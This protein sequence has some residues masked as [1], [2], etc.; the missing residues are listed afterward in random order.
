MFEHFFFLLRNKTFVVFIFF[1]S[2]I[3]SDTLDRN[4]FNIMLCHVIRHEDPV[5]T[6]GQTSS[7]KR[8]MKK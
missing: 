4:I 6:T 2:N 3:T 8:N 7:L 1:F 5:Q